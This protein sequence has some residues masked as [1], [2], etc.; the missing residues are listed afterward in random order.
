[1]SDRVAISVF[2]FVRGKF[3]LVEQGN[4]EPLLL[5]C[6]MKACSGRK[7]ILVSYIENPQ[8]TQC[9]LL[10]G[11]LLTSNNETGVKADSGELIIPPF[12][13]GSA[14]VGDLFKSLL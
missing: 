8:L 14:I 1:M 7:I 6:S 4:K 10:P 3:P 5:M 9:S 11:G 2:S 12:E 13:A